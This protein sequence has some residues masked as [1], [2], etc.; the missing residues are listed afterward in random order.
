VR[1]RLSFA[2]S[3]ALSFAAAFGQSQP[4]IRGV[5]TDA[6]GGVIPKTV[7]T[8]VNEK[9]RK[10]VDIL[11]DD[12]GRFV[13]RDLEVGR[14]RIKVVS[15]GF[16]PFIKQHIDLKDKREV[17]VYMSLKRGHFRMGKIALPVTPKK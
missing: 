4:A 16:E 6:S 9:T 14:Y 5:V 13:V 12:T 11:S 2:I 10:S 15:P 1:R 17:V 3:G 7:V 8:V